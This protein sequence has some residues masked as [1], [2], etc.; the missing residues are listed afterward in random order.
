MTAGIRIEPLAG[1]GRPQLPAAARLSAGDIARLGLVGIL[2]RPVRAAL[3]AAGIAIG[4]AAM[5]AVLGIGTSSRA[6]LL[7]EIQQLGTN[8]LTAQPGQSLLGGTAQLPDTAVPAVTRVAGVQAVSAVG[9]VQGAAVYRTDLISPYATAG[10]SVD[11]AQ[12]NLLPTLHGSVATG[13]FLNAANDRYPVTVLGSSAASLLGI[14]QAGE[15]VYLGGRWFTVIGILRPMP[16]APGVN[17]A[18]LI[19]WPAA[20]ALLNFNGNPTTVY[21]RAADAAVNQVSLV[22]A[23]TVDPQYPEEVQVTRPSDALTAELAAKSTF[24]SLFLGL[25]A[26]ALLVGGIGVANIMVI[27][28]L[29]RWQEIGLRRALGAT[30]G[31]IRLQFLTESV[32]LALLGGIGGVLLGLAIAAGYAADRGWPATI[33]WQALA[34]GIAA[35]VIIGGVAGLYPA[36]RAS[37]VSPAAALAT[38]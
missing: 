27:S 28:V 5:I 32:L 33:P 22:L 6:S 12:L 13:T 8:M 15:R 19:G 34:G 38:G 29:E 18:A 1:A 2:G 3:S 25:G 23:A 14:D 20:Q 26:V 16:L 21:V 17:G 35:S 11:A 30:A 4:V 7:A 9:T 10:I 31:H 24:N 37:R 36:R